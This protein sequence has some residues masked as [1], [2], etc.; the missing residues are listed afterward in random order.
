MTDFQVLDDVAK[1][2]HGLSSDMET[3]IMFASAGTLDPD[4]DRTAFAENREQILNTAQCLVNDIK[5]RL[6]NYVI[7]FLN[8]TFIKKS[9][10]NL[11]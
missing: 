5:E 1:D 4:Q 3:T 7:K 8:N 6:D 9:L 10:N 11:T 2:L